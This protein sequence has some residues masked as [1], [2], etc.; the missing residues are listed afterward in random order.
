MKNKGV[1]AILLGFFAGLLNGLLG[2]GGGIILVRGATGVLPR[3]Y[4]DGRDIFAN[5]L[6]V[7]LPLSA[8]SAIAYVLRGSVSGVDFTPFILPAVIGGVGGG[9]LLAVIDTRLLRFI[10]SALVVWSGFTMIF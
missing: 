10:F 4:S 5:A 1:R 9:M 7:M 6:C 8:V 2:A 3:E